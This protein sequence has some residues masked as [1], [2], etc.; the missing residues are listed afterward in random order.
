MATNIDKGLYSAPVGI[1][2]ELALGGAEANQPLEIEIVNPERVTLD[3]GSVE[4]TLTD[5][6][7][8]M[9]EFDANLAE[10]MDEE[11]RAGAYI[12]TADEL[13]GIDRGLE[14]A[15]AGRFAAEADIQA[16]FAKHRPA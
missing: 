14:A 12:P 13:A 3:D 15:R 9:G 4:I 11:V 8:Q 16:I 7:A 6:P 1:A 2:D 5:D 10:E